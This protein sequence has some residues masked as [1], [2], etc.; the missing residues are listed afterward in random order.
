MA[1]ADV[2]V[3]AEHLLAEL[4]DFDPFLEPTSRCAQVVTVLA[5]AENACAFARSRTALRAI[6]GGEH[7]AAGCPDAADWLARQ[8]GL[9]AAEARADMSTADQVE[10]LAA[11]RDALRGGEVSMSQ[12]KEIAATAREVPDAEA[13]LLAT[14]RGGSLD[15]VRTEGRDRRLAAADPKDLHHRQH[16]AR[17]LKRWVDGLGM[18]CGQWALPPDVGVAFENRLDAEIDRIRDLAP[19]DSSEGSETRAQHGADALVNLVMGGGAVTGKARTELVIVIDLNAYRRGTAQEDEVCHII[20]GG[21]I[22]ADIAREMGK[23]AFLKAVIHDGVR[24]HTIKHF[25]RYRPAALQTALDLGPPPAFPGVECECGCGRRTGL[26]WD[27]HDPV[28]NGGPTCEDNLGPKC[29]ESHHHKTEQD[30]TAGRLG[31]N[32]PPARSFTKR[33]PNK[34]SRTGRTRLPPPS[35]PDPP[36]SLFGTTG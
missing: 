14:A 2:V 12:A 29:W 22:P 3:A 23:D 5:R 7:A 10:S 9:S 26:Q 13:D 32:A 20:G 30:R 21:P 11:T 28:A 8:T 33:K 6:D 36:N 31:P 34:P 16:H 4:A 18:R 35:D 17:H 19:T 27:H 24:I 1:A 15:K 25:G